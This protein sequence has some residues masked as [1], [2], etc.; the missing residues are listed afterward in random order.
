M[1]FKKNHYLRLIALAS[2]IFI[3]IVMISCREKNETDD[4]IESMEKTH[5]EL[6]ERDPDYFYTMG[7]KFFRDG[8]Y[9]PAIRYFIL[10]KKYIN[11]DYTNTLDDYS[12]FICNYFLGSTDS[13]KIFSK[14][15]INTDKK[16]FSSLNSAYG[17]DDWTVLLNLNPGNELDSIFY[18]THAEIL[19]KLGQ[20]SIAD[21]FANELGNRYEL[22]K[23]RVI[24]FNK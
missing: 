24:T 18:L 21:S 23:N 11:G 14:I 7:M 2:F 16:F 12:I 1:L 6:A 4:E 15:L 3:L 5:R 10:D 22:L 19:Y 13:A 17:V 20:E 8:Y 9:G